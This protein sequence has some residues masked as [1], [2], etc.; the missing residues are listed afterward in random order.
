MLNSMA[1]NHGNDRSRPHVAPSLQNHGRADLRSA[2]A[3]LVG[4]ALHG[5][6]PRV[7][8]AGC[9]AVARLTYWLTYPPFNGVVGR[10]HGLRQ[11]EN[12]EVATAARDAMV[13]LHE[14]AMDRLVHAPPALWYASLRGTFDVPQPLHLYDQILHPMESIPVDTGF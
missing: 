3:G 10:T 12:A 7:R 11:D 13:M 9:R 1:A 6:D 5:P 4:Q 14:L 2:S 8:A